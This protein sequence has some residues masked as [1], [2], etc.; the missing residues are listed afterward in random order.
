MICERPLSS[1]K[2]ANFLIA[3]KNQREWGRG[4]WGRGK[5]G[6]GGMGEG[7]M[8]PWKDGERRKQN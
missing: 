5:W 4:E 8:D 1:Q 7:G 2:F 6:R 3:S